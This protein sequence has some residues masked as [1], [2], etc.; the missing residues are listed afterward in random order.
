MQLKN[1]KLAYYL[2]TLGG[3]LSLITAFANPLQKLEVYKQWE[4]GRFDRGYQKTFIIRES[5]RNY[6]Y[7]FDKQRAQ[8]VAQLY[9]DAKG[10]KLSFLTLSLF[11]S[12]CA[13]FLGKGMVNRVEL[14]EEI[15]QITEQSKHQL[16]LSRI[17]HNAALSAKSQEMLFQWELKEFLDEYGNPES[18]D[19]RTQE[20]Y[21]SDPFT[22]CLFLIQDGLEESEAVAQSWQV[23]QGS[24]Q[25][26][27]LLVKYRRWANEGEELPAQEP[28]I[29]FRSD[30]PEAMDSSSRKAVYKALGDGATEL[31]IVR[32]VLGCCAAQEKVGLAYLTFLKK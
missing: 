2:F 1:N 22:K 10:Y 30:F 12:G 14:E 31:E 3:A 6:P 15:A 8:K 20:Q 7:G 11:S 16:Q 9:W 28:E 18:D 21:Q 29:D 26:A 4:L 23:D 13:Y 32:E 24:P 5:D 27:A 17:K 25:H 19:L